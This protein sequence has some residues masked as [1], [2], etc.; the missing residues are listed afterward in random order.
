MKSVLKLFS[1]AGAR[2]RLSVLIF[3]RVLAH[4]DAL[5]PDGIDACR[6]DE[7]MTWVKSMFQVLPLDEAAQ[8]LQAGTLPSCAAALT[9]DDGYA[10]NH[11]QALPILRRHGLPC[12]F[13][14]ATG[15]LDGGR[16]WNDSLIESVRACQLATLDLCGLA[17]GQGQDLGVHVLGDVASR[18]STLQALIARVKY[19]APQARQQLVDEIALRSRVRLPD[20]LMMSS[21]QVRA[22]HRAG[23]QIGAHTVSHPI[24]ASLDPQEARR[25]MLASKQTLESLLGSRVSLFAYPNGKPGTD[26]LPQQHPTIAR[27]LGFE[28]AVSTQWGASRQGDDCFQIR[29]FTPWDRTK[30]KFGARMFRNLGF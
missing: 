13:F 12:T 5:F 22:L 4:P 27:E 2:G 10:D 23:M 17:D 26:Y 18:R 29:R 24:L 15:F 7:M 8:R 25:E 16:M 9:F 28:A 20:D 3:H 1:P 21:E 11:D 14:V 19:L 6:F 30:L